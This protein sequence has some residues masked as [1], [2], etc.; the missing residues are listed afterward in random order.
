ME[1]LIVICLELKT[2]QKISCKAIL[3]I[4]FPQSTMEL[5]AICVMRPNTILYGIKNENKLAS[6]LNKS[7]ILSSSFWV[8]K[9]AKYSN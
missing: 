3:S 5:K 9:A 8:M 1:S 6:W 4:D 7:M 2:K